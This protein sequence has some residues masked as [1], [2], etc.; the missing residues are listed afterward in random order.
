MSSPFRRWHW[1][2]LVSAGWGCA[3]TTAPLPP[4][5]EVLLVVN[6]GDPSLTIFPVNP[7]S[8]A[9]AIFLS[10]PN[11]TPVSVTARGRIALVPLGDANMVA[12]VDLIAKGVTATIP[13][14][15]GSLATEA[16]ILDDSVAYVANR[17]LNSVTRINYLRGDTA[18]V[19]VGRTPTMLLTARGKLFVVNANLAPCANA[20]ERS[21][22]GGPS[23][24]TVIDP[25]TNARADGRDSI[26]LPGP[27][28]AS[29]A[30]IGG[31]GQVYVLSLGALDSTSHEPRLS[32][33]DPV[34]RSEIGNFGGFGPSPGRIASDGGDRLFISSSVSGLME[35]NTRS[36]TIVRGAGQ[37]I[38]IPNNSSAAVDSRG[39]V[40][41]IESGDCAAHQ[42]GRIRI[43]R[44]DLT[45]SGSFQV[46]ICPVGST[47]VL[48]PPVEAQLLA[49]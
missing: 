47:I 43:F 49:R 15:S 26:P 2:V 3:A 35:F 31:D 39:Q 33:I 22:I 24:I 17:N 12:V 45:E 29:F 1:L 38:A 16:I 19:R 48:V 13:L 25:A 36:H 7:S 41:A 6:S 32:I 5:Q 18:S 14:A 42:A 4:P 46:G 8:F 28:N 27:G 11:A 40:Y 20:P 21:C 44:P 37:G 9:N 30:G 10:Y 34:S 23:W